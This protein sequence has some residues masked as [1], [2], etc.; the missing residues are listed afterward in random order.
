MSGLAIAGVLLALGQTLTVRSNLE[1]SQSNRGFRLP[2]LFG[3]F[4]VRPSRGVLRRRLLGAVAILAGAWQLL[5]VL[6][7]MRPGW[8]L[9]ISAIVALGGCVLPPL[10]MTLRHNRNHPVTG[11]RR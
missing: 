8:A 2:I 9:S 4:A 7:D 6:W 5:D 1:I 10:V 11:G 3:R